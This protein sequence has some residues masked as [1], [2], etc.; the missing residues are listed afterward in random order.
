MKT[1]IKK[2]K[3]LK[4]S[5]YKGVEVSPQDSWFGGGRTIHYQGPPIEVEIITEDQTYSIMVTFIDAWVGGIEHCYCSII[6][7]KG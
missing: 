1:K 3:A 4:L 2:F 7:H 5:T 6:P